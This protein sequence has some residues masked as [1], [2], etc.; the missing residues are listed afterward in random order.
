ML[1]A[2]VWQM[3]VINVKRSQLPSDARFDNEKMENQIPR[4]SLN[5]ANSRLS[6]RRLAVK[7]K[8]QL[9]TAAQQRLIPTRWV[10]HHASRRK[11]EVE[12]AVITALA[13]RFTQVTPW[14]E[15]GD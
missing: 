13:E 9:M 5:L 7:F 8:C 12:V 4:L 14:D 2:R 3:A 11:L 6:W 15:F 10:K 1:W